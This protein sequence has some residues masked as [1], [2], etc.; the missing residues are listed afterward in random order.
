MKIKL[1]VPNPE[2]ALNKPCYVNG[3][4]ITEHKEE[5]EIFDVDSDRLEE[6]KKEFAEIGQNC[7]EEPV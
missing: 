2:D 3:D 7:L 4:S 5:A 1:R 6:V